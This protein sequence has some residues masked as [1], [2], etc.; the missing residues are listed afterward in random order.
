MTVPALLAAAVVPAQAQP[1]TELGAGVFLVASRNL[2]DPNFAETV[3]LVVHYDEDDGAMGL[4]INRPTDVP[5]SRVFRDLSEAKGR[6]DPV[7]SGGPVDPGTLLVLLK[8]SVRP[9]DG[10][11]IF[12]GVYLV[13]RRE[14]IT[15]ALADKVEPSAFHA[16]LGYAGWAGGQLEHELALGGWQLLPGDAASVFHAAPDSV[17]PRLIKRTEM[18]VARLELFTKPG[19]SV[20]LF[21]HSPPAAHLPVL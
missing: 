17:W 20:Q 11:K 4:I 2:G 15:K 5:M 19:D 1:E 13:S 16:Y 14:L 9:K 8:T 18:R 6:T 21:R 10:E 7:Y 12:A 3:V